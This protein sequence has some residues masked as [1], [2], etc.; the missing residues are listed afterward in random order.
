MNEPSPLSQLA[1]AFN[2]EAAASSS[3]EVGKTLKHPDGR[4]VKIKSGHFLDPTYGRISNFWTWNEVMP[5]GSLGSDECG[6]GW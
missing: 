6:Y 5:D 3:M 1:A 4:T 2:Q